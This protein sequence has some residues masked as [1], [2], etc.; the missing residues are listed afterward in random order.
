LT[1]LRF[2][3]EVP[4]VHGWSSHSVSSVVVS[5]GL[6]QPSVVG[7][8]S[9]WSVPVLVVVPGGVPCWSGDLIPGGVWSSSSVGFPRHVSSWS[10]SSVL[11]PVFVTPLT[12]FGF[13]NEAP[14]I[15]VLFGEIHSVVVPG[16]VSE[17][18]WSAWS[19]PRL[20]SGWSVH[21]VPAAGV[22]VWS[23]SVSHVSD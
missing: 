4:S 10:N 1:L 6:V 7:S 3:N 14:S 22:P 20:V 13:F 17:S 12:F 2:F 5:S 16:V 23:W 19:I 18:C 21:L 9:H 8:V 11:V 15:S